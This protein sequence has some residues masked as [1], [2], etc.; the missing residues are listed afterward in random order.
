MKTH[1]NVTFCAKFL[2]FRY[3]YARK[4]QN[5]KAATFL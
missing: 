5:K 2:R 3:K 1:D 4:T